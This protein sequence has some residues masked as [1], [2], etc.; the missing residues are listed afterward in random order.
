MLAQAMAF[1]ME[2]PALVVFFIA[3]IFGVAFA[4]GGQWYVHRRFPEED[5]VRH[6]EVGAVIVAIAGTLYAVVLGFLTVAAWEHYTEARRFVG[7]ESAAA[8]D[9]WHMAVGLPAA[10][11]TRVRG[12]LLEY[13]EL[14]VTREWPLMRSGGF[15]SRGDILV[16]DAIGTAGTLKPADM[17]ESNAQSETM[18]QLGI[19]HDVRQRRLAESTSD[20]GTFAWFVLLFGA[21]CI[22]CFCW[23]F[24]AKNRRVHLLMTACVAVMMTSILV[25][26]FELQ[27]PFRTGLRIP[28]DDWTAVIRHIGVMQSGTQPEMRM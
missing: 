27:Y 7:S 22:T 21:A 3:V 9:A 10:R 6:N 23:L 1:V 13:A 14:M 19:L 18:T 8:A 2:L 16:M 4:C 12:D 26:L 5:F 28:P 24:G 15:D 25:L 20:I 11:R 17:G